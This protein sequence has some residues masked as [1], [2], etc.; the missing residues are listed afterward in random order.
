MPAH[1][2]FFDQFF[3]PFLF[4][5]ELSAP[6]LNLHKLDFILV[7][8]YAIN[9]TAYESELSVVSWKTVRKRD[10]LLHYPAVGAGDAVLLR[11]N[12]SHLHPEPYVY[13]KEQRCEHEQNEHQTMHGQALTSR[14]PGMPSSRSLP[15]GLMPSGS[16]LLPSLWLRMTP[17]RSPNL[18]GILWL[19]RSFHPLSLYP[20]TS[21][22]LP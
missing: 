14:T 2:L 11:H 1:F 13:D 22:P 3:Y 19:S 4:M 8:Y 20:H 5:A 21:Q 18:R 12:F 15:R 10:K 9:R 17:L 16:V 6:A 7:K